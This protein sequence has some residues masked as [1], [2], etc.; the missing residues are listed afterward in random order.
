MVTYLSSNELRIPKD[1]KRS[2]IIASKCR[3]YTNLEYCDIR[4]KTG[5]IIIGKNKLETD[6]H[7][8]KLIGMD[9]VFLWQHLVQLHFDEG[10]LIV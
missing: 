1:F 7:Q 9:G 2:Q 6:T 10:T 3:K 4:K 5:E 8:T